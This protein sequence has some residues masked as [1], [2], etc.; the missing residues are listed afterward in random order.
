MAGY[1]CRD[2]SLMLLAGRILMVTRIII[3]TLGIIIALTAF[4]AFL[5][6]TQVLPFEAAWPQVSRLI[7]PLDE[8]CQISAL[9]LVAFGVVVQFMRP[10]KLPDRLAIRQGVEDADTRWAEK[11][12]IAWR[13]ALSALFVAVWVGTLEWLSRSPMSPTSQVLLLTGAVLIQ[14][15]AIFCLLRYVGRRQKRLIESNWAKEQTP[16][17]SPLGALLSP[18]VGFLLGVGTL[19]LWMSLLVAISNT[20]PQSLG[21]PPAVEDHRSILDVI[22]LTADELLNPILFGIPSTYGLV[23]RQPWPHSWIG[24]TILVVFRL[25]VAVSLFFILNYAIKARRTYARLIRRVL[26]E[27]SEEASETLARIGRPAGALLA[28]KAF[29]LRAKNGFPSDQPVARTLLLKAMYDFYHPKIL[30]FALQEATDAGACESDRVEALKYVCT[31]GDRQT[32]LDLLGRFVHSGNKD[33]R[34]G[35]SLICVAFEHLEC[36]QLLDEIGRQPDTPGEYRNAVIGA[37]VRLLGNRADSSGAAACFEALPGVLRSSGPGAR[38]MLEG[39]FLLASFASKQ[40]EKEIRAAWPDMPAGTRLYCLEIVLKIRAGVLPNPELLRSVL[41]NQ[42]PQ[43]D[44]TESDK[45]WTCATQDDVA[46]LVE[47]SQGEDMPLRD[48]ALNAL[49]KIQARRPDLAIDPPSSVGTVTAEEQPDTGDPE[50][51]ALPAEMATIAEASTAG[52]V[53]TEEDFLGLPKNVSDQDPTRRGLY[54]L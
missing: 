13:L 21:L 33:L 47:I 9:L 45:F 44:G 4:G 8:W 54:D 31:Y 6:A 32:A 17:P 35:A 30:A 18:G 28:R 14:S 26:Q 43:S 22:R 42:E 1:S 29:R 24:A 36:N 25:T 34:E 52:L 5:H 20:W 53:T 41:S 49:A 3:S 11:R 40:V 50:A 16:C 10:E 37:G 7:P 12:R 38:P 23:P 15:A 19:G 51:E 46:T 39:M 27:S 48:E 2:C